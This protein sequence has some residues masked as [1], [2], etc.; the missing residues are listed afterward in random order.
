MTL[1]TNINFMLVKLKMALY[2]VHGT[3]M[4]HT[5]VRPI[6]TLSCNGKKITI[7]GKSNKCLHLSATYSEQY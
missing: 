4:I 6:G 2:L 7:R 5:I 1:L 3:H